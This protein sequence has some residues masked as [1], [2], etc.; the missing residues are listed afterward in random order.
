MYKLLT[1]ILLFIFSDSNA[2]DNRPN[3]LFI[4]VDDL[5]TELGSYGNEIVKSP[6][7]DKLAKDGI[8][9]NSAYVQYPVCAPSRASLLTGLYPEQTGVIGIGSDFRDNIPKA[10]TLPQLFKN[11]GY[12]SARVG[13]IFHY[14]V[15]SQIGTNGQDDS[16]SWDKVINPIGIDKEVEKKVDTIRPN[17]TGDIGGTLTWLN[18]ESSDKQHTDEKVTSEAINILR[19]KNPE[20]TGKPLFLAVGYFRPHV[21]LIAPS[22]YFDLYPLDSINPPF[23][24][25]NDREDIPEAALADRPMQANMTLK[26][27]KEVIQAYYASISFIDHQ[28]GLLLDELESLNLKRNTIVVFLSDHG[29]HLGDHG[30]WQKG[31]L[32]ENSVR[33]PLI[34]S[35]P[36]QKVRGTKTDSLV[37]FV[38]IYPTIAEI[39]DI[40]TP[41]YLSGKSLIPIIDNPNAVIRTSAFSMAM[42]TAWWTRSELQSL[43]QMGYSIRTK[44]YRYTEW[45]EGH[46]GIEMYHHE[47]DPNEHNNLNNN[48]ELATSKL[49]LK[50]LLEKRKLSA[51][52]RITTIEGNAEAQGL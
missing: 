18:L 34:L 19:Q 27:K 48:R 9:F 31:D 44:N 49:R 45:S 28:V 47:T 3:V 39:A 12:Y 35:L 51:K 2:A 14:N 43:E 13:K 40:N 41:P 36:N 37:E 20:K 38:D 21:P 11:E 33:S 46:A 29:F 30:L 52:K 25:A 23:V 5:N 26:Q 22:K 42:S 8:Q 7:I 1:I 50:R 16:E 32:F 15:P 6:N 4:M 10:V 24:P 17:F